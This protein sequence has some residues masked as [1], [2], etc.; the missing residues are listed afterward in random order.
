MLLWYRGDKTNNAVMRAVGTGN[1]K[2]AER[3]GG[4]GGGEDTGEPIAGCG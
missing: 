4:R 3:G 2:Q 1:V